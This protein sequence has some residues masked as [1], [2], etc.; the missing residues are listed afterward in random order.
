MQRLF[1]IAQIFDKAFYSTR[2]LENLFALSAVSFIYE[3]NTNSRIEVSQFAETARKALEIKFQ[4]IE[5]L[6]VWLKSNPGAG[7]LGVTDNLET[8]R[9]FTSFVALVVV[10]ALFENLDFGRAKFRL[11]ITSWL[12][13][14]E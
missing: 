8:G 4:R 6:M 13:I 5:N 7:F 14:D 2:E 9:L 12:R 3:H 10:L 1:G 11:R